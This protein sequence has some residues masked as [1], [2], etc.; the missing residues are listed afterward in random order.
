MA[1]VSFAAAI[2]RSMITTSTMVSGA[3]IVA[4]VKAIVIT[5]TRIY[6]WGT[7]GLTNATATVITLVASL[8]ATRANGKTILEMA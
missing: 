2:A 1:G 8:I 4:K 7:G 6:T 3:G 5:T